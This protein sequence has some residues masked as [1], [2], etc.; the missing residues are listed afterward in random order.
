MNL[1]FL[2]H[3]SAGVSRSNPVV[4]A[5]RPLDKDG[6]QFCLQL[7]HVLNGMKLQ[8]D[9]I[10]S[11]PLKRSLQTAS[12]IGTETAYERSVQISTALS[13]SGTLTAFRALLAELPQADNV[14]IVGH[15]PNL[16]TFLGASI[17]GGAA[18]G[19]VAG[20]RLRKGALARVDMERR[21]PTLMWL[22]DP[23][24]VRVLYLSST[25]SSRRKTSKK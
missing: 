6:K 14:L 11:S 19:R 13:P 24:I 25:K 9:L 1:Y 20:I 12:L 17:S 4:D 21:P 8:F 10:I 7:A 2:R 18:S 16:T 22:L 5:K 15:N 23:R 3:A